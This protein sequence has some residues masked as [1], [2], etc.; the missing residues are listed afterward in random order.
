MTDKELLEELQAIHERFRFT[1]A[2]HCVLDNAINTLL[3]VE[4]II[5]EK[6]E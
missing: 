3:M 6:P 4:K 1:H 5:K 2:G